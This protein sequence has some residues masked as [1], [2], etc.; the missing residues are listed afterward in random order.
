MKANA[1]LPSQRLDGGR[2]PAFRRA[3]TQKSIQCRVK[4]YVWSPARLA[5]R[6]PRR[7][8]PSPQ[9]KNSKPH[10]MQDHKISDDVRSPARLASR[11]PQR[12]PA[13]GPPRGRGTPSAGGGWRYLYVFNWPI[14]HFC[15][16]TCF[17]RGGSASY[18]SSRERGAICG[19]GGAPFSVYCHVCVNGT[20]TYF[21]R[22]V[23]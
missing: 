6:A 13:A 8:R 3:K 17:G 22:G 9:G 5:L 11:A 16:G 4:T 19:G 1:H 15:A 10:P 23:R 7:S 14:F 20:G 18:P 12:R 2:Q 21:G